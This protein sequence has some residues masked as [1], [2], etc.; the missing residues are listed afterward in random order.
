M[1][2]REEEGLDEAARPDQCRETPAG[3]FKRCLKVKETSAIETGLS[4]YKYYAP[5][6]GLVRDDELR[7][8]KHGFINH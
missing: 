1:I 2:G 6:I 5:G 7:L 3:V 4:E 8:V